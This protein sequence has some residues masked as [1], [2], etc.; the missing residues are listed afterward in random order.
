M[1]LPSSLPDRTGVISPNWIT[2][3]ADTPSWARPPFSLT[4]IA[5]NA[6]V[7]KACHCFFPGADPNWRHTTMGK[8]KN[9]DRKQQ[10]QQNRGQADQSQQSSMEAQSPQ[11]PPEGT[12][13]TAR[14]NRQK[15]FGHN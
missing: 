8:N 3:V 6:R 1:V 15:S 10:Q 9:R 2:G 4:V 13:S 11:M 12:P 7:T 14:K 5:R